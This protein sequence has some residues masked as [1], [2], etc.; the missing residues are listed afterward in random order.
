MNVCEKLS[1]AI[2]LPLLVAVPLCPAQSPETDTAIIGGI[3]TGEPSAASPRPRKERV[4]KVCNTT[5]RVH[6]NGCRVT[7]QEVEQPADD[8]VFVRKS[9]RE[10]AP[11]PLPPAE[12]P[13]LRN[14]PA[15]VA[16]MR[17]IAVSATIYGRGNEKRTR[18]TI[19][20][21]DGTWRGWSTIDF[22]HMAGI[23]AFRANGRDYFFLLGHGAA[24][25]DN[26]RLS[27]LEDARRAG[28]PPRIRRSVATF[29]LDPGR[30]NRIPLAREYF[31]DLHTLYRRE[32]TNLTAAF[33]KREENN[34]QHA[35]RRKAPSRPPAPVTIRYWKRDHAATAQGQGEGEG[36]AAK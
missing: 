13:V 18:L 29:T 16:E 24:Y 5:R 14:T 36:G 33:R 25:A 11:E 26:G 8:P 23:T 32:K 17:T 9:A 7:L 19:R 34:R 35:S 10:P 1:A 28:C 6:P 31:H 15:A 2:L 4:H 22:R 12:E 3:H 20:S 30:E 21:E 27:T